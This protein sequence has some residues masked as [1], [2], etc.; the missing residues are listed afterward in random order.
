MHVIASGPYAFPVFCIFFALTIRGMAGLFMD[1]N[2]M[3]RKRKADAFAVKRTKEDPKWR[4]LLGLLQTKQV[5]PSNEH[6]D[7]L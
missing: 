3:I 4:D 2:G 1:G 5:G 6:Y 7:I